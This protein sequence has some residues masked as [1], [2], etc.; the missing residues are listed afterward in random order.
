MEAS[1]EVQCEVQIDEATEA[2]AAA[3]EFG[4][5]DGTSM[6]DTLLLLPRIKPL[7]HALNLLHLAGW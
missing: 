3:Y 1:V 5:F 7:K 6:Y 4:S 2:A